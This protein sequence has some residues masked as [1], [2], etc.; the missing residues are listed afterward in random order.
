MG[1]GS[2]L[3]MAQRAR[4]AMHHE[5]ERTTWPEMQ[6]LHDTQT[7]HPH[8]QRAVRNASGERDATADGGACQ[9]RTGRRPPEAGSAVPVKDVDSP[10]IH[11]FVLGTDA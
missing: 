10:C 11:T 1:R 9:A 2:D 5:P 8:R 3:I 4:G 6:R 7:K